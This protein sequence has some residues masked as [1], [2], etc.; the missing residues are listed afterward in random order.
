MIFLLLDD[1]CAHM[2]RIHDIKFLV[3][4]LGLYF[5][6]IVFLYN[7]VNLDSSL[8][9]LN[10]VFFILACEDLTNKELF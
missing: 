6:N 8:I 5:V 4:L 9:L 2:V 10:F 3:P 7:L 1:N